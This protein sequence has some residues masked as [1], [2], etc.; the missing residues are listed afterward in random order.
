MKAEDIKNDP[1]FV[2]F[3][4]RRNLKYGTIVR[5]I[6]SLH[7]YTELI[8]M[9]LSELIEEAEE[10]ED[11]G[12]R[13]RRRKI[14]KYL[15][16]FRQYL[17]DQKFKH[18]YIKTTTSCIRAYYAEYDILLPKTIRTNA[19][20]DRNEILY[21]D[22]PSMK[23]LKNL[24]EY[25]NPTFKA[26][27]LL[28]VSSGMGRAEICSL[29]FEHFFDAYGLDPYP[30]TLDELIN[31]IDQMDDIVPLWHIIR[32]K[33][34]H[35]YFTFSSP[36][37]TNAIMNYL[38]DLNRKCKR[39]EERNRKAQLTL[40]PETSIFL[41]RHLEGVSP[42]LM[43]L[44]IKRLNNKA[45][46]SNQNDSRYIRP[47]ILRKIFASTLEKNKMPHLMIR[48]IMGH[49]LDK[50]TSAYFKADPQAVKEEYLE[51]LNYLTTNAVEI[52]LINQYE[53]LNNENIKL[54]TEMEKQLKNQARINTEK[55]GQLEKLQREIEAIRYIKNE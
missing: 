6:H 32:I 37:A 34:D 2:D 28:G 5:Y 17:E 26:I 52:K 47:H 24:L 12:M 7:L 25:A 13:L 15:Q 36:E 55:D 27:M 53:D 54:R 31:R 19:R 4:K 35:K 23:D 50:T 18:S 46:F 40:T 49:N 21:E 42:T 8:G 51:V 41:N 43:S 1:D 10:E 22:L 39:Y 14:R 20:S 29:T 30:K 16:E 45:G 3:C 11:S 48:W 33:T 9:T 38:K 44:T